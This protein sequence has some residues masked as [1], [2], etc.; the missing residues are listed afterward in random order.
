MKTN[1]I[2]FFMCLMLLLS[3]N[4]NAQLK[5]PQGSQKAKVSQVVGISHVTIKYS[6]PS[7]ND[8]EIWGKLVPYGMNNLGFGTAKESPWRAGANEN[9]T[10]E[11]SDNAKVEGQPIKAGKYGFHIVVNEDDSAT[12]IFSKNNSA[13]GSYFYDPAEDALRVD[14]KTRQ[15][16]HTELLTFDFIKVDANSAVAALNW[17][18]KQFPF[19][20]EFAV[21]DIVLA[22]FREQF[23]GQAGFTRQNWEQAANY[24]LNNGGDLKEALGW[25]D[26]AIAGQFFSQK[27]FNN[28]QVKSQILEKLNKS[29]EA[30]KIMEEALGYATIFQVHQYGRALINKGKKD[31]ALG[32]FKMNAKNNKNTWPVHYG[33]AR[34]YS[35][36]G[37]YKKALSHLK[38]A[39]NNAPNDASKG[40]VQTNI[41][42]LEN[43]Q[44][45]N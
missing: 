28:L 24:S 41:E 20:V 35:A 9:T 21:S 43:N 33:L 6:R 16:A 4:T 15:I 18:K 2:S 1:V 11:F 13:W 32:V 40:R 3:L 30:E 31:K 19:K 17:E 10:I 25:I 36:L 44:D 23:T 7:V 12:L 37:D 34:G 42:K 14:I 22:S 39:L 26:G 8:R 5:T 29:A 27:T 38:L 45:I